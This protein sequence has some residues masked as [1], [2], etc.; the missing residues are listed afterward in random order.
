MEEQ[1]LTEAAEIE[2]AAAYLRPDA[3]ADMLF[4]ACCGHGAVSAY[5]APRVKMV[6][7]SDTSMEIL[8][9]A[10]ELISER[11][12]LGNVLFRE[13][14][15]EDLSF[16]AGAFSLL[17]CRRDFQR[18]FDLQRVLAEFYRVLRW[19]GKMVFIDTLLPEDPAAADFY[20]EI[21]RLR[22]PG[23]VRAFR[24]EEWQTALESSAFRID[25]VRTFETRVSFRDWCGEALLSSAS[26]ERLQDLFLSAPPAATAPFRLKTFGG[27]VE[28]F[29][30]RRLLVK[31]FHPPKPVR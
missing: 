22:D 24:L 19:E 10:Q 27:V 2:E 30:V 17:C 8:K 15:P 23:Y 5:F 18:F 26:T 4:D 31:A 29:R 13:A 14:D 28:N 7:A 6:I 1:V 16:P 25:E 20:G 9:K 11:K 3:A 12:A 21:N